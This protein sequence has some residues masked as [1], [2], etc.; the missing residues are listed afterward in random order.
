MVSTTACPDTTPPSAPTDLAASNVTQTGLTLTWNAS[1]DN[2]GVAGYDVYRNDTK[3]ATVTS[4][5]S[6]QTGLA[7]GTSYTF[8]VVAFD[9]AGNRSPQAQLNATTSACS[10]AAPTLQGVDGGADYYGSFASPLPTDPAWFPIGTWGSY[11]TTQANRDSDAASGLNTYVWLAD[12]CGLGTQVN[13]DSRFRVIYD[14]SEN[15][16]CVGSATSGWSVGDEIDICCGP[17]A[18]PAATATT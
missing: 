8:A 15:R 18:S 6:S 11:N 13:G 16:S 10:T 5:S 4:T 12:P 2:V 17:P 1:T 9:A 7:C 3:M 14:E